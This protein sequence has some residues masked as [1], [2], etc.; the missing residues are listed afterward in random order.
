MK[1]L[2]NWPFLLILTLALGCKK[3]DVP[4]PGGKDNA[5]PSISILEFGAI[6]NGVADETMAFENAQHYAYKNKVA[7]YIPSGKY[8]TNITVLYDSLQFIGQKQPEIGNDS[9]HN[10]VIVLGTINA[11]NKKYIKFS[12]IGIQ[13]NNDAIVT[14]DGLGSLPL[15][16]T[17][18]NISIFGDGFFGYHHGILCQSGSEIKISNIKVKRFFHGIAI[19]TSNVTIENVIADHCG[20]TSIVVKSAAGGN[21]MVQNIN[22]NNVTIKG[23]SLNVFERGGTILVQSYDDNCVTKKI[24]IKNVTS[25][26][27]GVGLINIEQVKGRT[28][29]IEISNCYGYKVG[30]NPIRATFD[31]VGGASNVNFTNCTSSYSNGIGYRTNPDASN[32]RVIKCFENNSAISAFQGK[33]AFLELNNVKY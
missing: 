13:T 6:G 17:Y 12:N 3:N 7:I 24:N 2:M 8:K 21:E 25:N 29:S 26:Y 28:D 31:V 11:K 1:H 32:I 5:M 20:F 15:F 22:I 14:G 33:F 16:Q 4:V 9:L 10:G 27:G 19:R 23:D 30:D 18:S